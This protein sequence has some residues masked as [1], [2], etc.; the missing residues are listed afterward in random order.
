MLLN[1]IRRSTGEEITIE[2][3]D[4]TDLSIFMYAD[5]QRGITRL[6]DGSIVKCELWDYKDVAKEKQQESEDLVKAR[7]DY[8]DVFGKEVPN[9]K[10]ND[11]EWINAKV[12]TTLVEDEIIPEVVEEIPEVVV[13]EIIETPIVGTLEEAIQE[14]VKEEVAKKEVLEPTE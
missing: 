5:K 13:E 7:G 1:L 3:D 10:K 4:H 6:K 11:V 12:K 9:N 8:L 14:E 2:T